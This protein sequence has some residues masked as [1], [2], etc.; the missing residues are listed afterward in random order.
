MVDTDR[1]IGG[2]GKPACSLVI[3]CYNEEQHIGRLLTGITQ[4]TVREVEIIV[5]D[6]GS[7]DATVSIASRYAAKIVNIK[8]EE[9]SFGRS[10]NLGCA[11]AGGEF[12]VLA[13]AHCYPLYKDWLEHLLRP[14]DDPKVGLAYGK[15]KGNETTKFSEHQV[16]AKWFPEV[17]DFNQ[18]HPFCNN[19]NAAIRRELWAELPYDESLTGLEDLDWAKRVR[20]L[21]YKI[22]Y[23]ADADMVH[24]HDEKARGIYN[25]YRREAMA[26]KHIFPEQ[27]FSLWDFIRLFTGNV[28]SDYFHARRERILW[29]NLKSI[30]SFRF[31]QFWGTY[32]GFS[33]AGDITN[34]LKQTFY[35]PQGLG[36]SRAGSAEPEAQRRIE[37]S[38]SAEDREEEGVEK[39]K[40]QVVGQEA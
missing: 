34:Q 30:L 3:R 38:V 11:A 7:T 18:D 6:S 31:L 28:F 23:V 40:E 35:Y 26:H 12:L 2:S 16:F 15:Q 19:A 5:V 4:Q 13:S 32:R 14:F 21:G 39:P 10:L 33:R 29:G 27:R 8:P 17:S 20:P 22:A 36:R 37:Y 9:F 25:R 1:D 24:V